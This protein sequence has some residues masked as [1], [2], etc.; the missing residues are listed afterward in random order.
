[1]PLSKKS[2]YLSAAVTVLSLILLVGV[3]G[4]TGEWVIMIL[5]IPPII[6]WILMKREEDR[7]GK[8]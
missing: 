7:P 5:F 3:Y 6:H 8:L 1:M 2:K 4:Y